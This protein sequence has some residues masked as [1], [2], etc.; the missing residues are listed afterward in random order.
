MDLR[1]CCGTKNWQEERELFFS[2]RS[3][4]ALQ[5][6][7]SNK[8]PGLGNQICRLII[9]NGKEHHGEYVPEDKQEELAVS[10][11][12][13]ISMSIIIRF[14]RL[15]GLVS[16][17]LVRWTDGS[18]QS[19]FRQF[20]AGCVIAKAKNL[21]LFSITVSIPIRV[22][23]FKL[24]SYLSISSQYHWKPIPVAVSNRRALDITLRHDNALG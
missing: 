20:I 18:S 10:M 17:Q 6:L 15:T 5:I 23:V 4:P 19:H 24:Y 7:L 3:V 1:C 21:T 16:H 8:L 14:Q 12:R 13:N 11:T 9:L 2:Q 22:A